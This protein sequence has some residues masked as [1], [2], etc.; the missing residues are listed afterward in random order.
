M[1]YNYYI[2]LLH[3]YNVKGPTM[4]QLCSFA[5]KVTS[6]VYTKI[7][8]CSDKSMII[9]CTFVIVSLLHT[10]YPIPPEDIAKSNVSKEGECYKLLQ[11]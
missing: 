4:T 7:R 11:L 6:N 9:V 2:T 10:I 5:F 8:A 1:V 3:I